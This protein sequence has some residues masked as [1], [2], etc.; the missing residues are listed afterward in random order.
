MAA[1]SR[2]VVREM[3]THAY[4]QEPSRFAKIEFVL[5]NREVSILPPLYFICLLMQSS[6]SLHYLFWMNSIRLCVHV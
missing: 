6:I 2:A 1:W 5:K 3:D 4:I